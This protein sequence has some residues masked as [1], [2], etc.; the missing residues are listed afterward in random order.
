MDGR[1][2]PSVYHQ[3]SWLRRAEHYRLRKCS[4]VIYSG[5]EYTLCILLRLRCVSEIQTDEFVWQE[6]ESA[7]NRENRFSTSKQIS[8]FS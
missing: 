1:P 5:S 7:K 3:L 2:R 6:S 8:F 4:F